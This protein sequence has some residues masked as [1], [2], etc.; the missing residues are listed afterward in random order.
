MAGEEDLGQGA[1]QP[2][3][4]VGHSIGFQGLMPRAEHGEEL[5]GCTD[6]GL[7]RV[8]PPLLLILYAT[9]F[10]AS[11]SRSKMAASE[12]ARHTMNASPIVRVYLM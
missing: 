9:Y 3:S 2:W 4:E 8:P 1:L 12:H 10:Q 11:L 7:A 5:N 6:G